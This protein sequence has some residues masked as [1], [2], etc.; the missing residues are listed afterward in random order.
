[1]AVP[2]EVMRSRA[3]YW[4]GWL[5]LEPAEDDAQGGVRQCQFS[6]TL[7]FTYLCSL[8]NMGVLLKEDSH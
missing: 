6:I 3:I 5:D 1:M 4:V 2:D 8:M 7:T